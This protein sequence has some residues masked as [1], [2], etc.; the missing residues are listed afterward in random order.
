MLL[1][2]LAFNKS[3]TQTLHD[4]LFFRRQFIRTLLS[5]GREID[6]LH[7]I[8]L[9]VDHDRL[10]LIIDMI[11]KQ[12]AVHA[13]FR[14]A[15]DQLSL[16][17]ELK[18]GDRLVH[19]HI[20][21]QIFCIILGI[22][23]DCK[24]LTIRI[25]ID[26]H[27]KRGKRNQIDAVALFQCIKI[28][29]PRRHPDD[30]GNAGKMP[31]RRPHPYDIVVAPLHID[32]MVMLQ[33]IHNDMRPRPSVI[34]IPDDMQMVDDQI[35]YQIAECR[36]KFRRP[37]DSDDRMDDFIIISFFILNFRLFRDQLFD[38]IGK[39]RGQRFSDLG[40]GIFGRNPFRNLDKAVQRNLVPVL[41]TA[42]VLFPQDDIQFFLRIVDQRR[43]SLFIFVAKGIP[44][45]FVNLPAHGTGAVLQHMIELF[46]FSVDIRNKVFRSFWQAQNRL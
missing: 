7:V 40:T 22:I 43:K 4:L 34:N 2:L 35:L 32:R 17:L 41:N 42:L 38:D 14:P 18:D 39:I 28:S 25:L 36:N 5:H 12:P 9:P 26:F 1:Q 31:A 33:R 8:F 24:N 20:Q 27:R 44:E 23:F 13:K 37:A 29:I 16:Q 10:F 3:L 6:I 21:T 46:I 30:I 19:L 45:L 11:Q 15:H